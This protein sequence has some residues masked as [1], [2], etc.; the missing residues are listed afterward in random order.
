[1]LLRKRICVEHMINKFKKFKRIQLR[2]DRYIENFK[3]FIFTSA[4]LIIIK[5]TRI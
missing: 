4:L 2:Y 5:N 3:S 1:M